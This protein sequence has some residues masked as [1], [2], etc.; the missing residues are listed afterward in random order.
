MSRRN[1]P[2]SPDGPL[3]FLSRSC[4]VALLVAAPLALGAVEV[5]ARWPFVSCAA[6]AGLASWWRARRRPFGA[7]SRR[8]PGARLLLALNVL[9]L[10]QVVP[11]PPRLLYAVSPNSFRFHR[12]DAGGGGDACWTISTAP[13]RTRRGLLFLA[14]LGLL[15]GA[16]Y[17]EFGDERRGRR[18]AWVV[19]GVACATTLIGFVQRASDHPNRIYGLWEPRGLTQVFGPYANRSYYAGHVVMALPLVLALA[20]E[21]LL[22]ARRRYAER[23]FTALGEREARTAVLGASLAL[24]L[25]AGVLSAGSRTAVLALLASALAVPA[26]FGRRGPMVAAALAALVVAAAALVVEPG[27]FELNLSWQRLQSDRVVVWRDMLP[28][29]RD[30]PLFGVGLNA[31]GPAYRW[32]YQTVYIWGSWDQAHNEYLE[33]LIDTGLVGTALAAGL[34]VLL[35]R[36]AVRAARRSGYGVGLLGALAASATTH[37]ADFNLQI[38][39]NAATFVTI[40]GLIMAAGRPATDGGSATADPS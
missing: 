33:V 10:C 24:F 29:V 3:R 28:M 26:A 1:R 30:F 2:D 17:R 25:A 12:A 21:S 22:A 18:L 8:L 11:L 27:W 5:G 31:L 9:V 19:I 37:L 7:R 20:V 15:Y 4:V 36:A 14:A 13:V 39:A 23:G 35:M 32:N 34:A 16:V 6:L 40:A 38:P